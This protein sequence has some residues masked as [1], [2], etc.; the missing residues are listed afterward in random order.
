M[1]DFIEKVNEN[2]ETTEK[3]L[4]KEK[5]SSIVNIIFDRFISDNF[6]N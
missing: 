1:L 6:N 2:R 4:E 5:A 3:Q